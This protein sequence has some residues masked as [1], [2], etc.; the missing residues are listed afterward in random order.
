MA[1]YQTEWLDDLTLYGEAAWGRL[2]SPPLAVNRRFRGSL[3][4]SVPIC[5]VLR[6][7]LPWLAESPAADLLAHASGPAQEVYRLLDSCGAMFFRDLARAAEIV[8]AQLERVLGELIALGAITADGFAAL[9]PLLA[10]NR[11]QS[12]G[13]ARRQ[14]K[15]RTRDGRSAWR[16]GRWTRLGS[17]SECV[18]REE[19][20]ERWA[21][22]LLAR[23]GVLFRDVMDGESLAP[24]WYQLVRILR[25]MEARGEVRGGRFITG[26]A[27]EQYALPSA[28][29]QLRAARDDESGEPQMVVVSA[30][31]P[32]NLSGRITDTP[33][34]P[35]KRTAA[36]AWGRR[37]DGRL[38]RPLRISL[39]RGDG[40]R[41][42]KSD[43]NGAPTQYR[44]ATAVDRRRAARFAKSDD[45]QPL[46][47]HQVGSTN[48]HGAGR[49]GRHRVGRTGS[50]PAAARR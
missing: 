45:H 14:R 25:R 46:Y 22:L 19:H 36:V 1:E 30:A 37:S 27:G 44:N 11:P 4:R 9:R 5:V 34:V 12:N 8:P 29:E 6:D 43:R 17:R 35:A 28:V 32:L 31:D 21:K 16:G 38:A 24:P 26:V 50:G 18:E 39:A 2:R 13:F 49:I 41:V 33:R 40:T 7:D 10:G 47:A 15:R 20:A 23:W 42:A 3:H 48:V